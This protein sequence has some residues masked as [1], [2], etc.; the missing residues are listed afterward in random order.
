MAAAI[1]P[2]GD[3]SCPHRTME[4][5]IGPVDETAKRRPRVLWPV[6][7]V[8]GR[9]PAAECSREGSGLKTPAPRNRNH[10]SG[11]RVRSGG[12]WRPALT[13]TREPLHNE[14]VNQ[15]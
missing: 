6:H 12:A 15:E 9:R 13:A 10:G 2:T 7:V 4:A 14:R 11:G 1:P 5:V 3:R 8:I